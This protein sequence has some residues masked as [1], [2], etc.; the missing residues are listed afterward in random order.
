[1]LGKKTPT[2]KLF[3][4]FCL[5]EYVPAD[6]LLRRV[7]AAVDFSFV[8]RQT[9][10]FYSHTG[11]PSVDPI[12]LFKMSLLGYLY[13][14]TSERRLAQEIA[15]NLAYRWFVGYD[16]D[17]AIPD[18]SVLSKAR[19]RF[20]P[21]V[22]LAFLTEI[23]RQC[24]HAGLI[25]GNLLYVDSTLVEADADADRVG[26]RALLRQLPDVAEH[27]EQVWRDNPVAPAAEP[28]LHVVAADPPAEAGDLDAAPLLFPPIVAPRDPPLAPA[29]PPTP[30]LHLA[31]SGDPPN[32]TLGLLNERTV[33][34]TDPDAEVVQH[35]G[36]LADLYY[37]VHVGV[38]GA[39]ARIVTAVEVTGG[40]IADEH[41]LGRIICE[42]EGNVGRTLDEVVADTKYGTIANYLALEAEGILPSIPLKPT[43]AQ[44]RAVPAE[45]FVYDPATDRYTCPEGKPLTRQ[46]N[47]NASTVSGG[48]IYAAR[49]KDCH[50]CPLKA[51]CCPNAR[52]R[53]LF[54]AN[55]QG[56]RERVLR[57]LN[58]PRAKAALRRRKVWIETVFGDGKE[59]RGLRRARQRGLDRVR[60]Q[61]YLIAMAQNIRQLAQ[62]RKR[63]P[64]EGVAALEKPLSV[65][66]VSQPPRAT[67]QPCYHNIPIRISLN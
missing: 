26:S 2:G 36:V 33:S 18:H 9:A 57:H 46:G 14:I 5:E 20:G 56:V 16:L 38:D 30:A 50:A 60:I 23:V 4:Q 31:G 35:V 10:R 13:G 25:R 27:V 22:Y 58:T 40:G 49:E 3:Y 32:R 12:V 64:V 7:A 54:R 37:K 53:T 21:T 41:L 19:A 61:A 67:T 34:R 47:S 17:E 48:V 6:H 39:R 11:Q 15:L 8:R 24:E 29:S 28:P 43:T 66:V 65:G 55:D 62:A 45:R 63:G 52:S 59:R 44:E 1:M 42:H 51:A